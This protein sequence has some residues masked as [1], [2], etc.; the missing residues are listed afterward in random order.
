MAGR[1]ST[2][3]ART[4]AVSESAR[5]RWGVGLALG[6][7]GVAL[8]V[9]GA[10]GLAGVLA[11]RLIPLPGLDAHWPWVLT[12]AVAVASAGFAAW[13]LRGVWGQARAARELD[14]RLGLR[15]RL[16]SAAELWSARDAEAGFVELLVRDAE[17]QAET[18]DVRRAI[19]LRMG[20]RWG[21]GAALI[22]CAAGVGVYVPMR[23][24]GV[25]ERATREEASAARDAIAEATE[26]ARSATPETAEGEAADAASAPELEAIERIEQELA[27]G[28][29]DPG[30]ARAE[31]ARQLQ[32]LS[33]RLEREA[34]AERERVDATRDGLALAAGGAQG[35]GAGEAG[36]GEATPAAELRESLGAGDLSGAAR[37]VERLAREAPR[38]DEEQR[39]RAAQELRELAR[40][41]EERQNRERASPGD[42]TPSDGAGAAPTEPSNAGAGEGGEAA[43]GQNAAPQP[44]APDEGAADGPERPAGEERAP[45][46]EPDD[47]RRVSEAL[48]E[49]ADALERGEP[50]GGGGAEAEQR[51]EPGRAQPPADERGNAGQSGEPGGRSEN[52]GAP[53]G[54]AAPRREDG[55]RGAAREPSGAGERGA[56]QRG[57]GEGER[58]DEPGQGSEKEGSG[59]RGPGRPEQGPGRAGEQ[60][61]SREG[62]RPEAPPGAEPR[63]DA[64]PNAERPPD[65]G[66]GGQSPQQ[67]QS[68]PREGENP[69]PEGEG[70]TEGSRTEQ[71]TTEGQ[72]TGQS[73]RGGEPGG[74]SPTPQSTPMPSP[75][76]GVTGQQTPTT[77]PSQGESRPGAPRAQPEASPQSSGNPQ[78]QGQSP[79]V[80]QRD[81]AGQPSGSES[82]AAEGESERGGSPDRRGG[83]AGQRQGG[84]SSTPSGAAV[85]ENPSTDTPGT[86]S[87]TRPGERPSGGD[88]APAPGSMPTGGAGVER[89][90]RELERLERMDR[91]SRQGMAQS[92]AV[93]ERAEKLLEQASPE[94]R[95]RL[96]ELAERFGSGVG[97]G[98]P[99]GNEPAPR[100]AEWAGATEAVDA[101]PRGPAARSA[102]ES[103]IAEWLSGA[104]GSGGVGTARG[105]GSAA[106][107]VRQAAASAERA[108]EQQAVPMQHREL[109][110]RVFRR[111]SERAAEGGGP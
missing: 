86:T 106:E 80:G 69:R 21:W 24:P 14:H 45:A 77:A 60:P 71:Q 92:R 84:A 57:A 104:E 101:R 82:G 70:R 38:M 78:G 2:R 73:P 100:V 76:P 48:E 12:G 75:Q 23:E 35:R 66:A 10:A 40:A 61:G 94:E 54:E 87:G 42:A 68:R 32:Q 103:V 8:P 28:R 27:A 5:R 46:G 13:G 44:D 98:P 63:G 56:E 79:G 25:T 4:L 49:A 17:R 95:E 15:G 91:A 55:E 3:P 19:P 26:A 107:R 83:Q 62:A 93:R 59:T 58:R 52:R 99:E 89:L 85:P 74:S 1:E 81:A 16:G 34:L 111:F 97:D 96:E 108:V 64:R 22:A 102:N 105:G 30:E 109:V 65:A 36:S 33:D 90:S 39:R 9:G 6:S 88:A 37:A 20:R 43:P 29:A 51:P 18:V 31:A 7:L 72:P 67:S 50:G 11:G 47:A 110:R 41:I 53:P